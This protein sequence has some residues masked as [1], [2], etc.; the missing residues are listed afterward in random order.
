MGV[1]QDAAVRARAVEL[2]ECRCVTFPRRGRVST[3]FEVLLKALSRV[4]GKR[5]GVH[6]FCFDSGDEA[7]V[8]WQALVPDFVSRAVDPR[9]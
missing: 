6:V 7:S 9:F 5:L 1:L 3:S 2:G 4:V 8:A